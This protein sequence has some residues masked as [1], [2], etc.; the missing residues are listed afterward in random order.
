MHLDSWLLHWWNKSSTCLRYQANVGDGPRAEDQPLTP[1]AAS[2]ASDIDTCAAWPPGPPLS[3]ESSARLAAVAELWLR[4]LRSR[5][6]AD[7]AAGRPVEAAWEQAERVGAACPL[8]MVRSS[9]IY[10]HIPGASPR[11]AEWAASS[12]PSTLRQHVSLRRCGQGH[13]QHGGGDGS[14]GSEGPGSGGGGGGSGGGRG[15][16]GGGGAVDWLDGEASRLVTLL[17]LLRLALSDDDGDDARPWP[18]AFSFR[19]CLDDFCPLDAESTAGDGGNSGASI[20]DY[21]EDGNG[22]GNGNDIKRASH[23]SAVRNASLLSRAAADPDVL[24]DTPLPLLS[25]VAC[26]GNHR[27]SSIP[28]P[29]WMATGVASEHNASAKQWYGSVGGTRDVDLSVWPD[30]LRRRRRLRAANDARW[31]CRKPLAVW[32]GTVHVEHGSMNLGWGD[33]P[34]AQL[35]CGAKCALRRRPISRFRWRE[36]GRFA[37]LHQKC[38][39]ALRP[40]SD[41]PAIGEAHTLDL[42]S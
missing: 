12:S 9:Q 22:G 33:D 8:I 41:L 4:P 13:P 18:A 38:E 19:L 15:G 31:G 28:L 25:M 39:R 36:Q 23:A 37:L 11:W 29:Q 2:V 5:V 24:L 14:D 30:D 6:V 40:A 21:N 3:S 34:G 27:A 20:N 42:V 10:V 32:R 17:R 26:G 7:R 16:G 35:P 1:P